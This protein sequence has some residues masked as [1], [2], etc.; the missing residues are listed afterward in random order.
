LRGLEALE[1]IGTPEARQALEKL[2]AGPAD[3]WLTQEAKAS[4]RRLAVLVGRP[5]VE[6]AAVLDGQAVVASQGHEEQGS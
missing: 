3:A 6:G 5:E 4:Q 1:G 2:A